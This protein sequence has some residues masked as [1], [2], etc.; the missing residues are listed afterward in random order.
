MAANH[1]YLNMAGRSARLTALM[2]TMMVAGASAHA[3]SIS[4]VASTIPSNGDINPYGL[5]VVPTT[6]GALVRG[7]FLVSNFNNSD[8]LQG[9]GTTIVQISPSGSFSLFAQI[10][11]NNL[12]GP[13]PGG[14]GLTTALVALKSGWVIVGSLPT[15]DG[16][17]A[18]AQAGCLLVLDSSGNVVETFFGSLINGPWDMTAA[19]GGS[20]VALFVSNVLNGTVAGGGNVVNQGTVL[21]LNLAIAKGAMPSLQSMTVIGSGFPERTDPAALVIGPTGVGISGGDGGDGGDG[22]QVL[23]VADSLNNRIAAISNPLTRTSSGGT[24]TTVTKGGSLNDPL[25]LI[26]A[27]GNI[28][29]VNGNDGFAVE[30]TPD[31]HQAAKVLLD[32]SGDPPGAGALFGLAA[33]GQKLYYVDDAE[34]DLK[35]FQ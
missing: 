23:Y 31:G 32:S 20:S 13:C 6:T 35:L 17:A 5:A 28:V 4:V 10:D 19:D 24:G 34:N 3:H 16:M 18:T 27:N 7:N 33:V 26:V 30:T 29:T 12:P 9:T 15:T 8:N 25:G 14:V 1:W 2:L 11:A 22:G 21:R